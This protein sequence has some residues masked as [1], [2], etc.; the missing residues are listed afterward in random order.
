M[1]YT[2]QNFLASPRFVEIA[3]EDAIVTVAKANGQTVDM[4]KTAL[5]MLVP[6]VVAKVG[7]LI[8]AAA[9]HCASEANAGRLWK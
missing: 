6:N 2:A 8:L 1:T 9:E 7:K 4:T 5:E 3:T